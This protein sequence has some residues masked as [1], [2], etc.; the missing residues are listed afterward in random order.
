M[1]AAFTLWNKHMIKLLSHAEE[2]FGVLFQPILWV[3]LFGTGMKGIMASVMPGGGDYYMTLMVPE[4]IAL[5]AMSGAIQGGLTLLEERFLGIIKEYLVAPIPRMSI[6]MGNALSTI[7]K[8]LFQSV[9]ILT[10]GI[11][12]GARFIGYNPAGWLGGLLLVTLFG[13][14]FAGIGLAVASKT[15]STGGYHM[16]IFMLTLPLMFL[17]NSLYPLDSL[18]VWMQIGSKI[19]PVSYVVDGLRQTLFDAGSIYTEGGFLPLWLCFLVV[20]IFAV[21]GTLLSYVSFKK[22]VV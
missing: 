12:M 17:S 7:T 11:L 6:L 15:N 9:V 14:G 16:L 3:V 20:A 8:S 5:T 2:S 1:I 18:P 10:I 19:N 13:L 4:I 21:F 22:S